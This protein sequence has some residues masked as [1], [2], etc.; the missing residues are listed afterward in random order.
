[1][2]QSV[3]KFR[4]V[5]QMTLKV[6]EN[7]RDENKFCESVHKLPDALT[8]LLTKWTS[9]RCYIQ[10]CFTLTN[11]RKPLLETYCVIDEMTFLIITR[12]NWNLIT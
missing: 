5:A 9:T 2:L 3:V 1:M 12:N 11:R 4:E 6:S 7:V 8:Y 10:K